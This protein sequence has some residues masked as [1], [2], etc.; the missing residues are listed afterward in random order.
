VLDR[1]GS[2]IGLRLSIA[3]GTGQTLADDTH[4]SGIEQLTFTGGTGDDA[5]TGGQLQDIL[6]GEAGPTP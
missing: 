4:L 1:A 3:S 6:T 2:G 5:V